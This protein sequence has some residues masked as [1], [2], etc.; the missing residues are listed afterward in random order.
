MVFKLFYPFIKKLK[1]KQTHVFLLKKKTHL[2]YRKKNNNKKNTSTVIA[3][4][5]KIK[6]KTVTQ[7][8]EKPHTPAQR[9]VS[10]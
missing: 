4:K 9:L 10:N 1:L 2:S 8:I 3:Q 6:T 7:K 5:I